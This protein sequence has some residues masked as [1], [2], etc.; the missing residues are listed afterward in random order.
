MPKYPDSIS[1][2]KSIGRV[3]REQIS[4]Y[5]LLIILDVLMN[6]LVNWICQG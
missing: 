5:K 1:L 3:I 2:P 6:Q 4:N